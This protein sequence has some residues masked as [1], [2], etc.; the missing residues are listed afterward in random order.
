MYKDEKKILSKKIIL[1]KDQLFYLIPGT[2]SIEFYKT[3]SFKDISFNYQ[4]LGRISTPIIKKEIILKPN[5]DE[6]LELFF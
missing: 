1:N 3:N 6:V 2:Y 5:W 4:N